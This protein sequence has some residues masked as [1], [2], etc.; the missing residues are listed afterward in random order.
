M[1]IVVWISAGDAPWKSGCPSD[2]EVCAVGLLLLA[3]V[4]ANSVVVRSRR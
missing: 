1:L 4:I 3:A 2:C